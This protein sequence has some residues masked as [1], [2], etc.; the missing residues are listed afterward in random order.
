M[1][2]HFE[3]ENPE[4]TPEE[5]THVAQEV[6]LDSSIDATPQ[7]VSLVAE[8][9][10]TIGEEGLIEGARMAD[11]LVSERR[12]ESV[13]RAAGRTALRTGN[14]DRETL[15]EY[16]VLLSSEHSGAYYQM[17]RRENARRKQAQLEIA[18]RKSQNVT[19]VTDSK[20]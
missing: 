1:T 12:A 5:L 20:E 10:A 7:N 16:V 6:L 9:T 18:I 14:A 2:T 8:V 15:R 3:S 19:D 17:R 13:L 4:V 11:R